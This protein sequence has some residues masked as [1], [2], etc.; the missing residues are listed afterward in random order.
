VPLEAAVGNLRKLPAVEIMA[1]GGGMMQVPH[2]GLI[3]IDLTGLELGQVPILADHESQRSGVVGHGLAQVQSGRLI[4]AGSVSATTIAAREIVE[5]AKNGFPWQASVGV[6]VLEHRAVRGG[7]MITVNG[8]EIT[9]PTGGVTLV[10]RGRLREVSI[11]S[12]GCDGETAVSIAA[13]KRKDTGMDAQVQ[14]REVQATEDVLDAD[15][16]EASRVANIAAICGE[17][18]PD[19]KARA[20]EDGWDETRCELE[21]LR[22]SRPKPPAVWARGPVVATGL[23]L[24]ASLLSRM[25]MDGLGEKALGPMVMEQADQLGVTNLIDLCRAALMSDGRAVP[26]GRMELVRAALSTYSLPTALGNVANKVLLDSYNE[27]PASWRAFCAIR[28]VADF[29]TNTAIRPTFTGQLE[30][31]APGGELKHGSVAE[32]LMTFQIDTFGKMLSIDRRDIINDDLSLFQDAASSYGRMGMRKVS[33]LAFEVLLA[34]ADNFFSAGNGNYLEGADSG[35]N[36]D[37]LA[38]AIAAMRT[39]RDADGNDLDLMP[40]ILLVGPTLEPTARMLLESEYIQR[41]EDVPTGNSLRRAVKLEVEPRL[42]NTAKFGSA[43]SDKQWYLFSKP[44][45]LPMIVAFL[46]GRQT[47]TVEY[48]GLDQDVNKLAVS[49]RVYHDFGSALCDPRAAVRSKGE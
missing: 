35:L 1:Y 34:N 46:N 38:A 29:K 6:Q 26:S 32:A 21:V 2:W 18:Y 13:S 27:T 22:A 40:A 7:E 31:V 5:A 17:K 39:Q 36:V 4:V 30:Q 23:V 24:E 49:W 16:V 19:I 8:R 48:F 42:S 14:E 3:A 12:L 15:T 37:S 45:A 47:P 20:I 10:E 33:D 9:A 41:A 44:S 25:G 43:A 28:S 11:T